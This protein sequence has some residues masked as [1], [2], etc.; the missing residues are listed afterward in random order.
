VLTLP[1]F[2]REEC[3]RDLVSQF[4]TCFPTPA[5][6][7]ALEL[8]LI[9]LP[10]PVERGDTRPN[11]EP[12]PTRG[13]AYRRLTSNKRGGLSHAIEGGACVSTSRK[14]AWMAG[15]LQCARSES[16]ISLHRGSMGRYIADL[17]QP[18]LTDDWNSHFLCDVSNSE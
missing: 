15:S 9:Y 11:A 3:Y 14:V 7:R 12:R 17:Y 8:G 5:Q 4:D 1:C 13:C 16:S 18:R 10:H 6:R 2:Q